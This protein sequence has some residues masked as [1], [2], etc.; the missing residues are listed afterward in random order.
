MIGRLEE[1]RIP[2][3]D[4]HEA[5]LRRRGDAEH[6]EHVHVLQIGVKP[7]FRIRAQWRE[8]AR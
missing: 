3:R 5:H 6:S 4:K 2:G 7:A 8:G 1:A